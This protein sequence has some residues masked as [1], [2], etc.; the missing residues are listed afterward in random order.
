VINADDDEHVY[1]ELDEKAKDNGKML[2]PVAKSQNW[3][4][5]E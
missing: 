1:H 5:G 4:S 3:V 2:V